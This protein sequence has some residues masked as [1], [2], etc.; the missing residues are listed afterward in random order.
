MKHVW[1]VSCSKVW[2]NNK[3]VCQLLGPEYGTNKA[4]LK[5]VLDEAEHLADVHLGIRERLIGE[6]QVKVKDW[7][8]DNYKK[9]IVG[10]CKEAKTFDDEFRKVKFIY[11]CS[12]KFIIY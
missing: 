1:A 6:V 5:G 2:N 7:K 9:Q 3:L 10:G 4:S 8:N 11:V 12:A